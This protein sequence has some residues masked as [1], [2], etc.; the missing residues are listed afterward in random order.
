VPKSAYKG[1]PVT[2][3]GRKASGL[4]EFSELHEIAGLPAKWLLAQFRRHSRDDRG[5]PSRSSC[6]AALVKKLRDYAVGATPTPVDV[7]LV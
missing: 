4:W 7:Y 3:R 6:F 1:K 5:I 2:R